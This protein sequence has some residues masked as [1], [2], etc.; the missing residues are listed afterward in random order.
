MFK[1]YLKVKGNSKIS[2]HLGKKTVELELTNVGRGE[3][4]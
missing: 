1:P 3:L 2:S 4:Y